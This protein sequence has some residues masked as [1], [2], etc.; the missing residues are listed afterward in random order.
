VSEFKPS[1]RIVVKAATREE[2][3][4]ITDR[5]SWYAAF[6]SAFPNRFEGGW[7]CKGEPHPTPFTS[8]QDV[9]GLLAALREAAA[10]IGGLKARVEALESEVRMYKD[11]E[12]RTTMWEAL[13]TR[14]EL[15]EI[16][17]TRLDR[18]NGPELGALAHEELE[19]R[20]LKGWHYGDEESK[21]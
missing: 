14:Q 4:E 16:H 20:A 17:F 3:D 1:G 21:K 19:A 6:A 8:E 7:A 15:M 11:R 18:R 2:L 9:P 12:R 13:S 5:L 10:T